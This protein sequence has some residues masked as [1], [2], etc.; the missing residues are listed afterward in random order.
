MG[1]TPNELYHRIASQNP[2]GKDNLVHYVRRELWKA[3]AHLEKTGSHNIP[4]P[5]PLPKQRL[6]G[7]HHN[8]G[9]GEGVR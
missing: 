6:E 8:A 7:A 3:T 5:M 1:E 4:G 9:L 2:P